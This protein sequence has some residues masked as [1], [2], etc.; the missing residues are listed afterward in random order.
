MRNFKGL[1]K[2][3]YRWM[4]PLQGRGATENPRKFSS[5]SEAFDLAGLNRVE[6]REF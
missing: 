3:V 6:N 4:P 5:F 1:E 2:P